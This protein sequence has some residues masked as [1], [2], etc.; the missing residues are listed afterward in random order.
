[1]KTTFSTST[2]T[3]ISKILLKPNT[4]VLAL[5]MFFDNRKNAKKVFIVLSC[6]IYKIISNYF[7]IDYLGSEKTKLNDLR[8]G[9]S[10]VTNIN[11]SSYFSPSY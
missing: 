6:V 5:G 4:I 11:T 7:C 2:M 9:I 1:M 8:L 3:H 10:G